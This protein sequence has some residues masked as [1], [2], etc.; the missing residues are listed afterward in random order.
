[1]FLAA[2]AMVAI[3]TAAQAQTVAGAADGPRVEAW[4]GL[5]A[6]LTQPSGTLVSSYSPP[7]LAD[8]EF[9]SLGRQTLAFAGG[10]ATGF[11]GGI[12]LFLV[13]RAG[14]QV[15]VNRA[16]M[17]VSGTNGPYDFTL[18]YTSRPPPDYQPKLV[19]TGRS[20]PWPDTS[21][22]VTR[23]E[24]AVNGVGRV[25]HGR[26]TATLSGGLSVYAFGGSVQPLAY[27]TFRLGGHSVLFE[28]DYRLA[29]ALDAGRALGFNAGGD[30][31][32][33]ANPHVALMAGLRFSGGAIQEIPVRVTT[34]L[35]AD[36]VLLQQSV[37][38]IAQQFEPR[39][40]RLGLSGARIVVGMKLMR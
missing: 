16:S 12:N 28:S 37:A 13:G 19:N 36:E 32:V 27:T 5:S 21:G 22:R 25:G 34:I 7:L 39:P 26:V 35:N 29:V 2:T 40:V 10:T 1:M 18:T 33:A 30:L 31:N 3:S 23:T 38:E 4:G 9:T 11:E 24:I 14:V 8:G 15:L 20:T 17:N 6:S